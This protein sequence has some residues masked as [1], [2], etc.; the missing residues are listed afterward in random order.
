[1]A[2]GGRRTAYSQQS[3]MDN[4]EIADFIDETIQF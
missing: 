1:M 3:K 4:Q 2:G